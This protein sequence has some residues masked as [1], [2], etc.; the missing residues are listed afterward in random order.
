[1]DEWKKYQQ[2]CRDYSVFTLPK[3]KLYSNPQVMAK[4]CI[5][6]LSY[7]VRKN[8]LIVYFND[9]KFPRH[10]FSALRFAIVLYSTY[11]GCL[12]PKIVLI[13]SL[14]A[15]AASEQNCGDSF[16]RSTACSYIWRIARRSWSEWYFIS[17]L[18]R[19]LIN[20]VFVSLSGTR[21]CST[22]CWWPVRPSRGGSRRSHRGQ[23]WTSVLEG[24]NVSYLFFS[25]FVCLTH[26]GV[27]QR[28][29]SSPWPPHCPPD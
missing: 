11:S 10:I 25:V 20:M 8:P 27:H 21:V 13:L 5:Q 22:S 1:M 23:P 18:F 12:S 14:R 29:G 17:P 2:F 7:V 6:I 24:R 3:K 9:K 15:L 19:L 28:R 26:P 16:T 4:I